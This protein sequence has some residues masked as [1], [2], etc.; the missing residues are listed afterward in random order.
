MKT[1]ATVNKQ[2]KKTSG[3]VASNVHSS[4]SL[5]SKAQ[6]SSIHEIIQPKLSIGQANDR[7]EREADTVADHV[8]ADKP[9]P[10]I[11]SISG[12]LASNTQPVQSKSEEE[13]KKAQAKLIQHQSK[14][15]EESVQAKLIQRLAEEEEEPVQ[16]KFIQR[17]DE[18]EEEPVQAKFIQRQAEEEEEPVQAKYIQRQPEEE[19]EEPAQAKFIQRQPEEEEEEEPVQAKY[20]QRQPEEEKEEPAQAK[21]IQRQPQ[22][23]E[24]SV[25]AEFIQRQPEEEKEEPAQAKFI[26]RQAEEEEEP[27][28]AKLIQRK[29][30]CDEEK[31]SINSTSTA[32]NAIRN[33]SGGS[34]IHPNIKSK[35]ESGIGTDLSHV[36]VHEDSGSHQANSAIKA[37]AFTHKNNIYLGS[38]QSQSDIHLMAH[39]STHVVQQGSASQ[40]GTNSA[41][42]AG[43]IQRLEDSESEGGSVGP[44]ERAKAMAAALV[45]KQQADAK[46]LKSREQ[47][48]QEKQK[49]AKEDQKKEAEEEKKKKAEQ[50]VKGEDNNKGEEEKKG[51]KKASLAKKLKSAVKKGIGKLKKGGIKGDEAP[52]S[53]D[54]DPAFQAVVGKS[55]KEAT[56]QKKHKPSKDEA[57][58]AQEAAEAPASEVDSKAQS[59]QVDTMESAE[60]PAFDAV[61][62]K[63]KLMERIEAMAPKTAKE[64]DDF[65]SDGK[66]G[67]LKEEMSGEVDSQKESTQAPMQ[68]ASIATPD[69]SG[70]E[71]KPVT[72]LEAKEAGP[73]AGNINPEKATI[74]Q[75]GNSQVEDPLK[76]KTGEIGNEMEQA[77][78]TEPQLQDSNEQSFTEA[79]KGKKEAESQAETAPKEYRQFESGTVD[80]SKQGAKETA[81]A[82][83]G[84]MHQSRETMTNQVGA[85]QDQTKSSD[86]SK[87]SEIASDIGAIYDQTKVEV[88]TI[89]TKL[90]EDVAHAFD[91]GSAAAKQVFEDYVDARMTAYKEERYGGWFGWARWAK[92]KIAGMPSA[93]NEFYS[94]GRNRYLKEMDAV[95]N[96]VVAITGKGLTSAKAKVAEGKQKISEYVA[97]L[98]D[99][100]KKVGEQ[101]ASDIQDKFDSLESSIDAK[102][103]QLINDLAQKYNEN[104]KAVDAR[105]DEMKAANAG[106]VDKVVGFVK[107][108]IETIKKLKEMLSN[109]LSKIAGVIGDIIADPIGFLGNL[110]KGVKMG[111]DKFVGNIMKHL[112]SGLVKWLTGA[113][114]PMGITI[115][116]D[117]FSLKGIFSLV[118]QVLG[119]TWDYFR[120]KAVKLLGEPVVKALEVGFE[121]FKIVKEKGVGGL[122]EYI[123]EQFSNLKEMVIEQIKSMIITQVITAGVK[124]I[125]GLLNPVGAFI[126]A[127]MAIYE[128]VKFFIERAAQIYEFVNSVV[129]S[130]ADIVKGNLGGAAQKVETALANSIPLII[131]FLASLLG[132]SGLAKKVQGV[133][134]KVRKKIDKAID[135][136]ILKAKKFA[137]KLVKKG[138]SAIQKVINW[139]KVKKGFTGRDNKSHTISVDRKGKKAEIVVKSKKRTLEEIISSESGPKKGQLQTKFNQVKELVGG[140]EPTPQE[141]EARHKRVQSLVNEITK[142]LGPQEVSP[143]VVTNQTSGGGR[144]HRVIANP[145]TSQPGNVRGS[146]SSGVQFKSLIEAIVEP[147]TVTHSTSNT[148]RR[149]FSMFSSSHLLASKI[150]GPAVP[151]NLANTGK[152]I[153]ARMMSGPENRAHSLINRG[154][155]LSYKT[156]ADYKEPFPPDRGTIATGTSDQKRKWLR[157]IVADSY[158]VELK[159]NKQPSD[160]KKEADKTYGPYTDGASFIDRLNLV[161]EAPVAIEDEVLRK[162]S[163][164]ARTVMVGDIERRRIPGIRVLQVSMKLGAKAITE[165][166]VKLTGEG[167]LVEIDGKYYLP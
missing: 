99:D 17:Q 59:N 13:D 62:F 150:H 15:E 61:A 37:K 104:L 124:W 165:A 161:D 42:G 70:I 163:D 23:E 9:A 22:E 97:K 55:K 121:I 138:K 49:K 77:G 110:I 88:E 51:K 125:I 157:G 129:D 135:K 7:Y 28:Q 27:V 114:G 52:T 148:T 106:L 133:I 155:E 164:M 83:L 53:P 71:P 8:V 82:A 132:I 159:V 73:K 134:K 45:A 89:L 90:D 34:P 79:L 147:K 29:D 12:S 36:R 11:S 18:E 145:L 137:K 50:E 142:L 14:E 16:A 141:Q 167:K 126:K 76:E 64:A 54:E 75:K 152:S 149:V 30:N 21:F 144:A 128:I 5:N 44:I 116:E 160:G 100:L 120:R 101:A 96:N 92:D 80:N 40:K 60:T 131:G 35:L 3:K 66:V 69:T 154:A 39:E 81:T 38:G 112:I 117:I 119:L 113:L 140:A 2:S 74:K 105:I 25:Q 123:K 87:R 47:A 118:T 68:E 111:F 156:V 107:G 127:A 56:T 85:N 48:A 139:W 151:W 26:Q 57:D 109:L 33:N 162:A 67:E 158:S 122:W 130:I 6:R 63:A 143:S 1:L 115:P 84:E 166:R 65:K 78:V 94:T 32:E 4:M 86:E 103:D 72:P 93:V 95:I 20:I 24:E 10:K 19:K 98:P 41:T 31:S 46:A 146:E 91:T 43:V 136:I 108:V 153:N 102:Q 58:A